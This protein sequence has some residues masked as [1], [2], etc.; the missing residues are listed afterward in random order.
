M[1]ARTTRRLTF[2]PVPGVAQNTRGA[3]MPAGTPVFFDG[4]RLLA[5][6]DGQHDYEL[7]NPEQGD[8]VMDVQNPYATATDPSLERHHWQNLAG[9]VVSFRAD[10]SIVT[11]AEKLFACRNVLPFPE[12]ARVGIA[13]AL[14]PR[15]KTPTS[16]ITAATGGMHL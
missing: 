8:Y 12:L 14:D 7:I 6:V 5:N 15:C 10:W 2:Q 1:N 16:I 4:A 3:S 13:A 11:V 9:V